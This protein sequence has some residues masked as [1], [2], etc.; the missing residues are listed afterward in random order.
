MAVAR[1]TNTWPPWSQLGFTRI[2]T[3]PAL[4]VIPVEFPPSVAQQTLLPAQARAG[5]PTANNVLR[6][7]PLVTSNS[8][9]ESSAASMCSPPQLDEECP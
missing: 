4:Q 8:A 3:G 1:P 2:V 9:L 7:S 5:V 6:K